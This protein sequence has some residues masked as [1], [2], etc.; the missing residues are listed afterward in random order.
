MI[1]Y[2]I[3]NKYN[4]KCY[5]GCT[6]QTLKQRWNQHNWTNYQNEN[7]HKDIIKYGKNSFSVSEIGYYSNKQDALDAEEYYI[8]FYDCIHPNGY[9]FNTGGKNSKLHKEIKEKIAKTKIGNLN[10]MFGKIRPLSHRL[11]QSQATKGRHLSEEHKAAIRKTAFKKFESEEYR[12][13]NIDHLRKLSKSNKG[14]I[15]WNKGKK[16]G[17]ISDEQKI[18]ISKRPRNSF[19]RFI[20]DKKNGDMA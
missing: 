16:L 3:V 20:K 8:D 2:R 10:P 18:L 4:G 14:K 13:K 7:L 9:N 15:P 1:V 19:G 17:P 11:K 5:V 12:Q 6:S